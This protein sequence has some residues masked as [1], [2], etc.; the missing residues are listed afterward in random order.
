M[1]PTHRLAEVR[2]V[3]DAAAERAGRSPRGVRLVAVTKGRPLEAVRALHDAGQRD[4]GE[5]RADELA[6]KARSSLPGVR[7]HF[8]GN[9]QRN[10]LRR[11]GPVAPLVHSFDRVDLVEAWPA[12]VDVLL[13]V[14]VAG[15]AQ[16]NG[17]PPAD[18]EGALAALDKGGVRCLGLS[19]MP[20]LVDDPERNRPHFRALRQMRDRLAPGWPALKELSMGTT[21]DFP[22]AVEE[23]ATFV[24]VGRALF[25]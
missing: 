22:V 14:N 18:V 2:R 11:L 21:A 19:L 12:G 25:G 8:I 7:W 1:A 23:G 4:F 15:E 24:R 20:P 10:K 13:Q 6:E 9:L 16:K 3:L 5:N 17:I